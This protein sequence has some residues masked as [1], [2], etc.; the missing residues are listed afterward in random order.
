MGGTEI[1]TPLE[2]LLTGKP[3]DGY[4]KQIFLLTDGAVSNTK[5]ILDL[6]ETNNKYSRVHTIGI[7]NGASEDLVIGCAKKGKGYHTFITDQ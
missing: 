4:P 2:N 3:I 5:L 7:G 6:I 1:Y